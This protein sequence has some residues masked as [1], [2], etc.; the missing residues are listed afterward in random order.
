[1]FSKF[2]RI[3]IALVFALLAA[4]VTL[5]MAEAQ[6][7]TTPPVPVAEQ[8]ESNCTECHTEYQ[9]TWMNGPHGQAGSDPVFLADWESQGKPGACLVCHTT[10]YDPATATWK[11]DSVSCEACHSA[12]GDEEHP[13]S[14]MST[15]TSPDLCGRCHSDTRFGWQ[16]WQGSTHYQRGMNC[17]TC[18]DPHSASLKITSNVDASGVSDMSQLCINCHQEASMNFPYTSH[19]QQGV[20]CVDCHLEHLENQDQ[21]PHTV[22]DHS[23]A[24]SLKTCNTCHADQMHADAPAVTTQ[25]AGALPVEPAPVVEATPVAQQPSPVSPVGY[26]GL[27]GLVGLAAGMVLAPWLERFYRRMV[28]HEH[29]QEEKNG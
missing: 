18:H 4:G 28:K 8:Q 22:P 25:D 23:F 1:M 11:S 19:H 9:M 26:A 6:E 12:S 20:A 16:D 13:K 15:D 5:I 3:L 10:G 17:V 24:A 2:G 7:G 21:A 29:S 14:T 27:A